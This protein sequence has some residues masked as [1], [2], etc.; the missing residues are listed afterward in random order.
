MKSILLVKKKNSVKV[1]WFV[2]EDNI[3]NKKIWS[4]DPKG[5]IGKI[6]GTGQEK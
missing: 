5:S 1:V 6:I 2:P 3:D 4:Q